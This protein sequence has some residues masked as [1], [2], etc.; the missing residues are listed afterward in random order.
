MP[1]FLLLRA[2]ACWAPKK[3]ASASSPWLK[4]CQP[5]GC[6]DNNANQGERKQLLR[7]LIKDVTLTKRGPGD[8]PGDPLANRGVYSRRG[9]ATTAIL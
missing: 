4:T 9:A 7:F 6:A 8:Q 3:R 2:R 5:Y 1:L